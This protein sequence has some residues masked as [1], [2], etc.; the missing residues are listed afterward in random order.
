MPPTPL[1]S[2]PASP[3]ASS[4]LDLPPPGGLCAIHQPN[5]FPRLSTLAKL[6]AADYWISLDDVQFTRRDYQHRARL[7][8]LEAPQRQQ[9]LSIPTHLPHGRSTIISEARIVDPAKSQR[10]L[11][12]LLQQYYGASSHWADFQGVLKPVLD[13]FD[14]TDST[15]EIAEASTRLLLDL[16]G[17]DGQILH[18]ST[19]PSRSGRTQ[20]LADL[21]GTT[22]ASAYLCGTGGMR[23]LEPD[24]FQARGI[25]VTPF[26]TP[27][28]DGAWSG[29]RE[30]SSLWAL[31]SFGPDGVSALLRS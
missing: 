29:A 25:G 9:W 17:W 21:A 11:A 1:S 30:I 12:H 28:A 24:L 19:L 7:A 18:S 2:P 23:Y 26:R 8:A 14:V 6:F 20:R 15:A 16:L 27:T 10:K 31:M 4:A 5:L 22:G 3:A 13:D